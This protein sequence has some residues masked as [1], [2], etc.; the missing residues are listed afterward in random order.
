MK[1]DKLIWTESNWNKSK[2]SKFNFIALNRI[3]SNHIESNQAERNRTIVT[4]SALLSMEHFSISSRC[5]SFSSQ[6][7]AVTHSHMVVCSI[8]PCWSGGNMIVL[9]TLRESFCSLVVISCHNSLEQSCSHIKVCS[10]R[11]TITHTSCQHKMKME[12]QLFHYLWPI[13]WICLCIP[14]TLI[15]HETSPAVFRPHHEPQSGKEARQCMGKIKTNQFH[16]NTH[17][18]TH[19]QAW[20]C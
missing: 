10:L 20:F 16:Q 4:V 18:H 12:L 1:P 9:V 7:S 15:F 8:C 11:H 3:K 14:E 19:I 17:T 2:Q 13:T 5:F 6:C